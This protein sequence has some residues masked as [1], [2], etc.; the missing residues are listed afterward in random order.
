VL[1]NTV[2]SRER[3]SRRRHDV[4]ACFLHKLG[5]LGIDAY[6]ENSPPLAV[7]CD[8]FLTSSEFQTRFWARMIT[9]FLLLLHSAAV[10]GLSNC[11]ISRSVAWPY[12]RSFI[13]SWFVKQ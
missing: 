2:V 8:A 10:P 5:S 3:W 1:C 7:A 6:A 12:L 11:S 9:R 4:H 13:H